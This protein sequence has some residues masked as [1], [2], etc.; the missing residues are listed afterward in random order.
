MFRDAAMIDLPPPRFDHTP[1]IPY[2]ILER[3]GGGIFAVDRPCYGTTGLSCAVV[4]T[5]PSGRQQCVVRFVGRAT[6]T[7]LRHEFGH[8]NGWPASHPQ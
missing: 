4:T 5:F 1:H 8:C 6:K 7:G 3:Q 2:V